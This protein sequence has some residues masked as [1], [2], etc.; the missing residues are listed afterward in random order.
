MVWIV[1]R[2]G[3]GRRPIFQLASRP[4]SNGLGSSAARKFWNCGLRG[5]IVYSWTVL[6]SFHLIFQLLT[7]STLG[8]RGMLKPEREPKENR[9]RDVGPARDE[10][11]ALKAS[12]EKGEKGE[13]GKRKGTHCNSAQHLET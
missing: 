12:G 13:R 6:T 7:R 8:L 1:V 5:A 10:A 9:E 11:K 2:N 3:R 4:G